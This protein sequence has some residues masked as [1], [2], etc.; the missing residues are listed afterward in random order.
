[1]ITAIMTYNFASLAAGS[2]GKFAVATPP[3]PRYGVT[4][5]CRPTHFPHGRLDEMVGHG[6]WNQPTGTM[7]D[8]TGQALC[9][10]RSVV[11]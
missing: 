5:D 1:M 9:I 4:D 3:T 11:E 2:V 6:T 8:D 7:A 10:E